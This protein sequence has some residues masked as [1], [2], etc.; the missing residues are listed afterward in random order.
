MSFSR[1]ACATLTA[2][3]VVFAAVPAS[4]ADAALHKD[5]FWTVGRDDAEAKGCMAS[6]FGKDDKILIVQIEPGH[7]DFVVGGDKRMR[8]GK[9]G[10]LTIDAASFDFE[11]IYTD[12]GKL[13]FFEDPNGRAVAALRAAHE[14]TVQLDG[15]RLLEVSV[16]NTGAAEAL[17][18]AAACSQGEKGWW[19]PGVGAQTAER[20]A[21]AESLTRDI[22]YDKQEIW[23]IAAG[24]NPGICVAQ[25]DLGDKRWLQ[26]LAADGQLGLAVASDG[27]RLPRG[28]K[29]AIKTDAYSFDFKP[30]YT[31][32]DHY[33]SAGQAFDSQA[34][35]ALS[36]A[37]WLG[38]TVDGKEL[39]DAA[40]GETAFP[41]LLTSVAACSKGEKGW[42]GEGAPVAR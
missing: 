40:V 35:F 26:I 38:V 6:I 1:R 22:V 24:K 41:D 13:F 15:R 31:D 12:D 16:E 5:G 19:G 36:R 4:A 34:L 25:A 33:M 18:A 27:A 11:P 28:R 14:V 7:A 29:G 8:R 37:K 20:G 42:W 30:K 39:V 23:G 10:V 3:S 9:K 2:A 17:D 21:G 32:D